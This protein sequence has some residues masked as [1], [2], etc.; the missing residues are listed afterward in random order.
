MAPVSAFVAVIAAAE[1]SPPAW[2]V[3]V[4]E[5]LA[6]TCASAEDASRRR[7]VGIRYMSCKDFSV[8]QTRQTQKSIFNL[9]VS[10]YSLPG[11]S[12][13]KPRFP[14]C[15]LT[16]PGRSGTHLEM[17]G[18]EDCGILAASILRKSPQNIAEDYREP[19]APEGI[20]PNRSRLFAGCAN[21]R[22]R[23]RSVPHPPTL[24]ALATSSGF[25]QSLCPMPALL[26]LLL[27]ATCYIFCAVM[28]LRGTSRAGGDT[29]QP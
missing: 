13:R 29:T 26:P 23:F 18:K 22:D 25:G 8:S 17:R 9:L 16:A 1:T 5:R 11:F 6:E 28:L 7:S 24:E 19:A 20:R 14:S 10:D 21:R 4:P 12:A 27:S 2:S 15:F 3:T